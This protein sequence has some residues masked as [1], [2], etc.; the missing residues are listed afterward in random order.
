MKGH[1]ISVTDLNARRRDAVR[2]R[3]QGQKIA[4][5]SAATGRSAPTIIGA[6]RSYRDGG[7]NAVEVSPRKGRP[8][9]EAEGIPAQHLH[10]LVQAM[11]AGPPDSAGLPQ[12]LW[13]R[14]AVGEWLKRHGSERTSAGTMARLTQTLGLEF[15]DKA[16]PQAVEASDDK[17]VRWS[18]SETY[19]PAWPGVPADSGKIGLLV[20][21]DP[22]GQLLWL[23]FAGPLEA[24]HYQQFLERIA[25]RRAAIELNV[26]GSAR[27]LRVPELREWLAANSTSVGLV[28]P[29]VGSLSAL[30][31]PMI[32]QAAMPAPHE[33]SS[34]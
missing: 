21:R 9:R 4:A 24:R 13:S 1:Q 23:A 2:L 12:K 5:V 18:G 7:W 31:S 25:T 19:L 3:L 8:P 27:L 30:A 17:P 10:A 32:L 29:E 28:D 6:V 15:D 14:R 26:P 11:L 34:M 22:R 16:L 33:R 20:A